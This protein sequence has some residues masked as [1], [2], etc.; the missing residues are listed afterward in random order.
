[1]SS[2]TNSQLNELIQLTTQLLNSVNDRHTVTIISFIEWIM[3]VVN[4]AVSTTS[5]EIEAKFMTANHYCSGEIL[6]Q[7]KDKLIKI[8]HQPYSES[9][10][11]KPR[12]IVIDE[13]TIRINSDDIRLCP[14]TSTDGEYTV[15]IVKTSD[16]IVHSFSS[17]IAG[18]HTILLSIVLEQRDLIR[19]AEDITNTYN[20]YT[21]LEVLMTMMYGNIYSIPDH[22]LRRIQ[23]LSELSVWLGSDGLV[24]ESH[25]GQFCVGK[26]NRELNAIIPCNRLIRLNYTTDKIREQYSANLAK[27]NKENRMS[28]SC[29]IQGYV[30]N[31]TDF[32]G[33]TDII[34]EK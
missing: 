24:I 23:S 17:I 7:I 5:R 15:K 10:S 21:I 12:V 3:M 13:V 34:N 2:S 30:S 8:T 31:P 25:G 18:D 1:M 27:L 28:L 22:Q 26:L 11:I 33:I 29:M 4:E 19:L 16:K 14:S 9:E 20:S 6:N 32:I